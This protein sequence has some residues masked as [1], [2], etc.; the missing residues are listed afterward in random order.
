MR[1]VFLYFLAC[2]PGWFQL[3]AYGCYMLNSTGMEW[4]DWKNVCDS[5]D[6]L[7][8]TMG[9]KSEYDTLKQYITTN[10]GWS[11]KLSLRLNH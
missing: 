9:T 11:D 2:D 7:L 8:V 1:I 3:D 4:S 6:A 5:N 10:A